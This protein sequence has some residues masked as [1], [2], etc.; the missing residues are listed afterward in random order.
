MKVIIL[1]WETR[2][3]KEQKKTEKNRKRKQGFTLRRT[4]KERYKYLATRFSTLHLLLL[5]YVF[6]FFRKGYLM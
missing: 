3:R 5:M 2:A 4:V 1:P 6:R